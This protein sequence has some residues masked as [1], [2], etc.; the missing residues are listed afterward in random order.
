MQAGN[1]RHGQRR[2]P[3]HGS[4][5]CFM[6]GSG[7]LFLHNRLRPPQPKKSKET[8]KTSKPPRFF[9]SRGVPAPI[10][11]RRMRLKLKAPT[12]ISCRFR[13]FS[14]PRKWVRLMPPVS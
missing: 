10:S 13:M 11:L 2:L 9:H 14:C 5:S 12:W 7:I 1:F 8:R 4:L 3:V 6:Q